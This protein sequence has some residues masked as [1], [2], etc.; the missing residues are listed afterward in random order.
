VR[1]PPASPATVVT[2]G[3]RGSPHHHPC[4]SF[5]LLCYTLRDDACSGFRWPSSA[6]LAG[7]GLSLSVS[8][9]A[10]GKDDP[11]G[12]N[13]TAVRARTPE[14][15]SALPGSFSDSGRIGTDRLARMT[16]EPR[17]RKLSK[18]AG[19][20]VGWQRWWA[21]RCGAGQQAPTS[22]YQ[23]IPTRVGLFAPTG[24]GIG[25]ANRG[26]AAISRRRW[27][28]WA[29]VS[30]QRTRGG[31]LDRNVLA[32]VRFE[33]EGK[34]TFCNCSS[35]LPAW[36]VPPWQSKSKRTSTRTFVLAASPPPGAP[37]RC[38]P[39]NAPDATRRC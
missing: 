33:S 10:S 20:E 24:F 29:T 17:D 9:P 23:I 26:R 15:F 6:I 31:A 30:S 32:A 25:D 4:T 35:R 14:R 8:T 3:F 13:V 27:A 18:A 1:R 37:C 28:G 11:L 2:S 34:E 16:S 12:R 19:H 22:L 39:R 38:C 5:P 7:S 36:G 21:T